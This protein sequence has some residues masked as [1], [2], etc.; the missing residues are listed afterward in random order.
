[1]G[2]EITDFPEARQLN[3]YMRANGN[4]FAV[5]AEGRLIR[6]N[7]V[8]VKNSNI[9]NVIHHF[10]NEAPGMISPP[11]YAQVR[12]S[13]MTDQYALDLKRGYNKNRGRKSRRILHSTPFRPSKWN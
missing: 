3:N 9:N 6:R 1:L 11:G 13:L 4:K 10:F 5:D 7:G 2:N 12:A 8:P